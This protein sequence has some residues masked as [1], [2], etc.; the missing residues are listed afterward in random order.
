ML[1][2]RRIESG[3]SIF[4]CCLDVYQNKICNEGELSCSFSFHLITG[5]INSEN[6]S[7]GEIQIEMKH[8]YNELTRV[9]I[10]EV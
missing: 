7:R 5:V 6:I 4:H 8:I 2:D 10:A 1:F 3:H 9:F